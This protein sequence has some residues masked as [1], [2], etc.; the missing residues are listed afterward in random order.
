MARILYN[1]NYNCKTHLFSENK[2]K[3]FFAT[4]MLGA[5]LFG[6]GSMVLTAQDNMKPVSKK[7][8]ISSDKKVEKK[9]A[10]CD[11]TQKKDGT[12]TDKKTDKKEA[13]CSDKKSGCNDAKQGH[14]HTGCNGH[15]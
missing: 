7:E 10:C 8:I 5:F 2:M 4:L 6:A 13:C 11:K 15:K 3:R 14:K 12:C 9:E 1:K